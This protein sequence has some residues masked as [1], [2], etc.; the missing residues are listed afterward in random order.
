MRSSALPLSH[1]T[2]RKEAATLLR[3][4]RILNFMKSLLDKGIPIP[5]ASSADIRIDSPAGRIDIGQQLVGKFLNDGRIRG[6]TP[7]GEVYDHLISKRVS[8]EFV[9]GLAKIRLMG[10]R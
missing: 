4:A 7:Q 1:T 2:G 9:A 6:V 3:L 10:T 8:R 5:E